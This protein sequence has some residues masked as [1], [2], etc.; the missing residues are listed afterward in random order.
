MEENKKTYKFTNISKNLGWFVN[1]EYWLYSLYSSLRAEVHY[2]ELKG[3]RIVTPLSIGTQFTEPFF[4]LAT[5][6]L[7]R[8]YKKKLDVWVSLVAGSE[9]LHFNSSNVNINQAT[10]SLAVSRSV[11]TG[12]LRFPSGLKSPRFW[13]VF[14]WSLM[15][16]NQRSP[17]STKK[18][19]PLS[20]QWKHYGENGSQ[21]SRWTI[22][23]TWNTR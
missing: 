11:Q 10:T 1:R 7:N 18:W 19:I 13:T 9:A 12:L 8:Q 2:W 21:S 17:Y 6:S 22:T 15:T 20:F 3:V 14:R 5:S 16:N 23:K 4:T